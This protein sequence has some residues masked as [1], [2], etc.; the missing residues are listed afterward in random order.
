MADG[1]AALLVAT[2]VLDG[3][4]DEPAALPARWRPEPV[5][6]MASRALDPLLLGAERATRAAGELKRATLR[7]RS[8]A[9]SAISGAG[10]IQRTLAEDFLPGA[11]ESDW[12]EQLGPQRTLV[13]Y[14]ASLADLQAARGDR[15][16]TLN[17]VGLAVVAGALRALVLRRGDSP[18][19]LKAMI[20]VDMRRGDKRGAM[21]NHIS[22]VAPWLPLQ[23]P[24][25]ADRL[26]LIRRETE[27]FKRAERPA[28]AQAVLTAA[29]LLPFVIRGVL[30]RAVSS[31]AANVT[32]SNVRG[33]DDA[34]AVLGARIDEIYPVVPIAEQNT[35]SVGMLSYAGHMH[36]GVFADPRHF[37][38]PS[39]CRIS[40]LARWQRCIRRARTNHRREPRTL[41][42]CSSARDDSRITRHRRRHAETASAMVGEIDLAYEILGRAGDPPVLL[43]MGLGAQMHYWPDGF[44]RALTDLGIC[45]VR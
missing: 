9:R 31:R 23:H 37:P 21:G 3:D 18:K 26:E 15:G 35:L 24:S 11:P 17:D 42:P 14:R 38:T 20:P 30:I 7:P 13:G 41:L 10:R 2:L 22:M 8:S 1:A 36:F 12:G 5:P 28:G 34:L 39:V 29:G 4:T 32:V 6:S 33:P 44:C 43:V 25:P 45:V 27:R 16:A 40:W 19:P